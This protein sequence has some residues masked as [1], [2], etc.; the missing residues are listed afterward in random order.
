MYLRFTYT[1]VPA[2]LKMGYPASI[3]FCNY[4]GKGLIFYCVKTC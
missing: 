4:P 2:F 1:F 3:I